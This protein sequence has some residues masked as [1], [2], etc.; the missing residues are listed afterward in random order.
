[1]RMEIL[2]PLIEKEVPGA[3]HCAICWGSVTASQTRSR[4]ALIQMLRSTAIFS[5]LV[6][7]M[8]NRLVAHSIKEKMF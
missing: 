7:P 8:C 4:G 6:S 3:N 2:F 5:M 1:M